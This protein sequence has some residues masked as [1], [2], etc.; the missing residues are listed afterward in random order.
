MADLI[1]FPLVRRRTFICRN[2]QRISTAG[3]PTA[4]RL[5]AHAIQ[6]QAD[7][8]TR[9][10][11]DPAVISREVRSLEIAIRAEIFRLTNAPRGD[12]A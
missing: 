10:G 11:F 4:E 2:A 5:L 3:E 9:R 6:Q 12:T 7:V 8:M 1:P